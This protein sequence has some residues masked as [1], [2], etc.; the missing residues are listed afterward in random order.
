MFL[1]LTLLY[2]S[3][4]LICTRAEVY[5]VFTDEKVASGNLATFT[6]KVNGAVGHTVTSVEITTPQNEQLE[7]V[8]LNS[9]Y[10]ASVDNTAYT[11]RGVY[12]CTVKLVDNTLGSET[13]LT[14]N[15]LLTVYVPANV[16]EGPQSGMF[17]EGISF[18]IHCRAQG[19]PIPLI[20][21]LRDGIIV[22]D[23]SLISNTTETP[24]I[25]TYLSFP[26]PAESQSA[27][28]S[29]R[30]ANMYTLDDNVVINSEDS[31]LASI[32]IHA[33][34]MVTQLEDRNV[35][36][37]SSV[38]I[39]CIASGRQPLSFSW[40]NLTVSMTSLMTSSELTIESTGTSSQ[41]TIHSAYREYTGYYQCTASNNVGDSTAQMLLLVQERP[42]P[43]DSLTTTTIAARYVIISWSVTFNGNSPV[44]LNII[45][46]EQGSS[47]V[48]V[49]TTSDTNNHNVTGLSPFTE[50]NISVRTQN[51]IGVSEPSSSILIKTS[52]D[53]PDTAPRN[54]S[55][56]AI[57]VDSF[58]V[59][60]L[61][62]LS[63]GWNGLITSFEIQ[64]TLLLTPLEGGNIVESIKKTLVEVLTLQ[65]IDNQFSSDVQE[66]E[67]YQNYSIRLS[68]CT[69]VGCGLYS[70]PVRASTLESVPTAG[71]TIF[72]TQTTARTI[73]LQW[74]EIPLRYRNGII[75]YYTILYYTPDG[76]NN[77]ERT[78]TDVREYTISGLEPY[79]QYRVS[80]AGETTGIGPFGTAL[81]VLTEEDIPSEPRDI[82]VTY[83]ESYTEL[84]ISWNSPLNHNGI[85]ILY[86]LHYIQ[87][88]PHELAR[89]NTTTNSPF[90][91]RDISVGFSVFLSI[92]ANTTRGEGPASQQIEIEA[93]TSP[94]IDTIS[95]SSNESASI[96]Y[97]QVC[98]GSTLTLTCSIEGTPTPDYRWTSNYTGLTLALPQTD[99]VLEITDVTAEYDGTFHC[100][101]EN[102]FGSATILFVVTVVELPIVSLAYGSS[103]FCMGSREYIHCQQGR[104]IS[105]SCFYTRGIPTPVLNFTREGNTLTQVSTYGNYLLLEIMALSDENSRQYICEGI[106]RVGIHRQELFINL[107]GVFSIAVDDMSVVTWS[108]SYTGYLG[109]NFVIEFGIDSITDNAMNISSLI[110]LVLSEIITVPGTYQWR[111]KFVTQHG[112]A[113]ISTNFPFYLAVPPET[114]VLSWLIALLVFL[115]VVVIIVLILVIVCLFY[116]CRLRRKRGLRGTLLSEPKPKSKTI[117]LENL[118]NVTTTKFHQPTTRDVD[119]FGK[120]RP[121]DKKN[122][123]TADSFKHTETYTKNEAYRGPLAF[124]NRGL[125]SDAKYKQRPSSFQAASNIKF[126][127]QKS[128]RNTAPVG[129]IGFRRIGTPPD[130]PLPPP[131]IEYVAYQRDFDREINNFTPPPPPVP[132]PTYKM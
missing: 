60:W 32:H 112:V 38:T 103:E 111:L 58:V 124:H 52:Q 94:Y 7:I 39:V 12:T 43:P 57:T 127:G 61:P 110:P 73:H 116:T 129:G 35:T 80:I 120:P 23:T 36:L 108:L 10:F 98:V 107:V 82:V 51:V 27:N 20:T 113:V 47:Y 117:P 42:F 26:N 22:S 130:F 64:H 115:A 97:E 33:I 40:L 125:D 31:L 44:T 63:E 79:T 2:L 59:S 45:G 24:N 102:I 68:A 41:L 17:V 4:Q 109:G 96:N 14:N 75:G 101:A 74:N 119:R 76:N 70:A 19:F 122:R 106:N 56:S 66:L 88:I 67:A 15:A 91:I 84:S 90:I 11:D 114:T 99:Q 100:T 77:T 95:A 18:S 121:R 132:D 8:S 29:C 128:S 50:Y 62:P 72:N 46:I 13:T 53:K 87:Y 37:F 86:T 71:P 93:A 3:V 5:L 21:W 9:A 6:C 104:P 89:S 118:G 1:L 55:L 126:L 81:Q 16:L 131:P 105:I 83:L 34:P 48:Q 85:I 78:N 92:T 123:I 25:T 28:Y 65:Q 54:V 49:S 30:V 69:I